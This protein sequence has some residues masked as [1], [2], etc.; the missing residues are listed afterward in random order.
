[1]G[2]INS[3]SKSGPR[4]PLK[5][6]IGRLVTRIIRNFRSILMNTVG[7]PEGIGH[8]LPGGMSGPFFHLFGPLLCLH[9]LPLFL[10]LQQ[11]TLILR[12]HG[13]R[14]IENIVSTAARQ[15]GLAGRAIVA[16]TDKK[17]FPEFRAIFIA[18][19]VL[20]LGVC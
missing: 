11:A 4:P 8:S 12:R 13:R 6:K 9:A 2:K 15:Q 17:P 1:M 5:T 16:A 18:Y 3:P 20:L 10:Q 14:C 7:N 19:L